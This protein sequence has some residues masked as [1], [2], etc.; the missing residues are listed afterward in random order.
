M[1][2]RI[3]LTGGIAGG[4]ST[5]ADLFARHGI[6]IIDADVVARE[7]VKPEQNAYEAIIAYFGEMILDNK[8]TIDRAKLKAIVFND[9]SK[10][11]WLEKLLHP[12]IRDEM[13]AQSDKAS[14]PYCIEVIPLLV[15]T[16]P[17]PELNRILVVDVS[18]ETQVK[19]L[20]ERERLDDTLIKKILAAQI[21]REERLAHADDVLSNE[22]DLT[23]LSRGVDSLH[24][25]YLKYCSRDL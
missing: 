14:S 24:K 1:T 15:E 22:G 10:R 3:G 7:V 11:L 2:Y 18:V 16:L 23:S 4:K 12:L 9:V 13:I 20:K 21:S 5:V 25:K 17:Y 19:R 6:T 8:R